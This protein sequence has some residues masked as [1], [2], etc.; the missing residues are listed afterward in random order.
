MKTLDNTFSKDLDVYLRLQEKIYEYFQYKEGWRVFPIDD[1][2]SYY[3]GVQHSSGCVRFADSEAEFMTGN[4]NC[5]EATLRHSGG[6]P[7]IYP[8]K[9]YTLVVCDTNTDGNIFLSIF[10]NRKQLD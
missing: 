9:D 1:S 5:Y 6:A 4:G 3:W 8:G 7:A 10:D 2:R